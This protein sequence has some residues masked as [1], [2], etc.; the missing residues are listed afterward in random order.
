MTHQL[1]K[2]ILR[3]VESILRLVDD[4]PTVR[5][6]AKPSAISDPTSKQVKDEDTRKGKLPV[7]KYETVLSQTENPWNS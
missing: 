7:E 1:F 2:D 6:S 5:P 3:E 4:F